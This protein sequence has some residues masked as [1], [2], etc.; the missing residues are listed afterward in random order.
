[1]TVGQSTATTTDL[2]AHW[3]MNEGSGTSVADQ[4]GNSNTGSSAANWSADGEGVSGQSGDRAIS[5]SNNASHQVQKTNV[6]GLNPVS[7][8]TVSIWVKANATAVDHGIFSSRPLSEWVNVSGEGPGI[9]LRYDNSGWFTNEAIGGGQPSNVLQASMV[10]PF[11]GSSSKTLFIESSAGTQVAGQ[12]QHVVLTWE[13]NAAPKF[14]FN[15]VLDASAAYGTREGSDNNSIQHNGL[16][17]GD[18]VDPTAF[19][20]GRGPMD[21]SGSWNGLMDEF[22]FYDRA[23]SAAEITDLYNEVSFAGN[24]A[25]V[26]NAGADESV[27]VSESISL[28]GSAPDPDASGTVTT[29]WEKKSGNGNATFGDTSSL[30]SSVSFDAEDTYVLRLTATDGD[31]TVFEEVTITVEAS[32][33][34]NASIPDSWEETYFPNQDGTMQ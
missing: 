21:A 26:V 11:G 33:Q 16:I 23:L 17:D 18:L 28:S 32:H 13:R 8:F 24:K 22:R 3:N 6:S 12:W 7:A 1:M 5:F 20:L 15:G 27:A 14:Y 30:T 10:I 4:S 34:R 9:S 2:M 29:T 31:V 19:V 25:P